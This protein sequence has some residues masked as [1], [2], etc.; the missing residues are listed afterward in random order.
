MNTDFPSHLAKQLADNPSLFDAT[1]DEMLAEYITAYVNGTLSNE[2]A[3]EVEALLKRNARAK[4]IHANILAANQFL[5]SEAGKNWLQQPVVRA[6]AAPS[7]FAI[8]SAGI[9]GLATLA[10]TIT[11]LFMFRATLATAS[12]DE[13]LERTLD[14]G[15]TRIALKSD[16]AGRLWL[17]VTSKVRTGS[18]KF[19]VEPPAPILRFSEIEP[20]LYSARI[21]VD[22]ELAA[23]LEKGVPK[24]TPLPPGTS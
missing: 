8:S 14:D 2:D 16:S 10:R 22:A 4:T 24:L 1:K 9:G 23:V 17:R 20:G 18:F 11:D 13:G 6:D 15:Q 5:S 3:A 21:C 12:G 19:D 7:I